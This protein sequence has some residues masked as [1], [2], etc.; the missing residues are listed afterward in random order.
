MNMKQRSTYDQERTNELTMGSFGDRAIGRPMP[1][2]LVL[3]LRGKRPRIRKRMGESHR[4][5]PNNMHVEMKVI[6]AAVTR[7]PTNSTV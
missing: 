7:M 5:I 2:L 1:C 3:F 6:A 4:V